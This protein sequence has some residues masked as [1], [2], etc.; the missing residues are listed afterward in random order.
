MEVRNTHTALEQCR[1]LQAEGRSLL[2]LLSGGIL[3]RP[4][5]AGEG[6][7]FPRQAASPLPGVTQGAGEGRGRGTAQASP[8]V[9]TDLLP[10]SGSVKDGGEAPFS[11]CKVS[12]VR[13]GRLSSAE[14]PPCRRGWKQKA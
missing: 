13:G 12:G 3:G 11:S 7:P 6:T 2:A 8:C 4:V 14:L 1:M 5:G 10:W 9:L